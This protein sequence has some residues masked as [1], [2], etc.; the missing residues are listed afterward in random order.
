[1]RSTL[2]YIPAEL[3]GQPIFGFGWLLVAWI[4]FGIGLVA[5]ASRQP[6]GKREVAGYLPLLLIVA[7]VIAFVLPSLVEQSPGGE[8][9]GVP[10]RGFGVMFMLATLAGV[11]LAAY[12]ARQ[13]GLDPEMI[14]SLAFAMFVPGIIGARLFYVIQY[15]DEVAQLSPQGGLDFGRTLQ[16]LLNVTKGGLVVYGSLLAAVPA[17]IWFCW[18]HRL[19][20]LKMGDV[21]APSMLVGLALGRIGCF[22]NGCCFGGVCLTADYALS[23]PAGSPPYVQQEGAGWRSGVWLAEDEGNVVVAYVAPQSAAAEHVRVGDHILRINGAE[24]QSVSDARQKLATAGSGLEVETEEGRV[25]RWSNPSPP[26]WSVPIHAT[27]LYAAIDASLL[28][29]VLWLAF[30]YRRHDGEV[31]ALMVTVHPIS[32]F[33]LEMIRSDEPGQFGT[34][35]T[36]SQWLSLGILAG[37]CVLWWYIERQPRGFRVQ[38]SEVA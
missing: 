21:I 6:Q 4:V 38:G 18:R 17:G 29:V 9:L 16:A 35:L 12:R 28:A 5:W 13:A 33:L 32:R 25:E 14:Y 11:G 22:F 24:V 1:M 23:F 15:W 3:A 31:F 19:P 20:I 10:I 7:V 30:A 26:A 36:I 34:E 37:A 8:P 2:F 27:Q